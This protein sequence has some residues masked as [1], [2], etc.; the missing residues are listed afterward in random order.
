MNK[1][2]V[3]VCGWHY[4]DYFYKQ[5]PS[6]NVPKDWEVDYFCVSHRNP[7]YAIGE[8]NLNIGSDNILDLLDCFYHKNIATI[9][10]IESYGWTYMEKPNTLGDWGVYNQWAEDYDYTDYDM[11]LLSG[12]DNFIIREDLLDKVLGNKLNKFYSNGD[13]GNYIRSEVDYNEDWIVLSNNCPQGRGMIRG[14]FD[15][16]KRKVM[17]DLGG[18]FDFT[19]CD[20]ETRLNKTDPKQYNDSLMQNWNMQCVKFMKYIENNNL[21]PKL[22]F[23]SP[24]YRV[25]KFCVEGERGMMNSHHVSPDSFKQGV[26]DL[27][28]IGAFNK[29]LENKKEK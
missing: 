3:V 24:H 7:K 5:L 12:D 1:L 4:P 13:V 28:N 9:E 10:S 2:A 26:L 15:F 22:R 18:V 29:F 8:K 19:G 23:L 17:D 11:F 25:S 6:Q 14:S 27:Y 21:Y 16:I 20:V